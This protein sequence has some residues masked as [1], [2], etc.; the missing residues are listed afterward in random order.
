MK[1]SLVLLSVLLLSVAAVAQVRTGSIYGT[2]SDAQGGPLPGVSVTLTSPYG[3]PYTVV[4]D[5]LGKFRFPSLTPSSGYALTAELQGFKKQEKTGIVVVLG[6]QSK[7]D[8]ALEQGT[9]DEQVTVVAVTPTIDAKKTSVGK[10]VTQEILQS[11]PSSRDPWNV[12]QMAPGVIM[13]R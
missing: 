10:N 1:K 9:L 7:I 11:L 5:D 6:Q 2:V 13:D 3:A 12:M 4:T 8:L